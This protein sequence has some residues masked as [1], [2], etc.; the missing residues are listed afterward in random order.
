[1]FQLLRRLF[2]GP[3]SPSVPRRR[4]TA[5][6]GLESLE[7]RTV[8]AALITPPP[9]LIGGALTITGSARG[10]TVKMTIDD[11]HDVVK[12]EAS[13]ALGSTTGSCAASSV[14]SIFINTNGGNDVVTCKL[15]SDMTRA[16]GVWM[17]LGNGSDRATLD[18][19]LHKSHAISADLSVWVDG[20]ATASD[21]AAND[22]VRADFGDVN[23]A[24]LSYTALMGGG[25]DSS[26]ANLWGG[27]HG[28]QAFFT[29]LGEGGDDYMRFY[30]DNG[31]RAGSLLSVN[32]NGGAGH[33][34]LSLFYDDN[35]VGRHFF[36]VDGGAGD[37]LIGV[38]IHARGGSTGSLSLDVRG[39]TGADQMRTRLDVSGPLTIHR[40][41]MDGGWDSDFDLAL[42]G[43]TPNVTLVRF[44]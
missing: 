30:N 14:R 32:L 12:V 35:M 34:T 31:S 42:P 16:R 22:T 8:P 24:R 23:A 29:M 17:N 6:P 33:D 39:G 18:F 27:L 13:D 25:N 37:D 3:A 40:A 7:D 41:V 2:T 9:P 19:G 1:M 20:Q 10:D 38:E 5:R 11:L 21:R 43:T 36:T 4:P 15:L 44:P 26:V 28:S